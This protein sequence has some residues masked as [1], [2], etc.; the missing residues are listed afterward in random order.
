MIDKVTLKLY[1]DNQSLLKL[2]YNAIYCKDLL[3]ISV[4]PLSAFHSFPISVNAITIGCITQL[5]NLGVIFL[6]LSVLFKF[7]A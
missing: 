1:M 4:S 2:S 6:I 3:V 7:A 5:G